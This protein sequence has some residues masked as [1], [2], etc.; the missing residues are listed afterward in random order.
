MNIFF[1]VDDTI[2]SS[3]D[4]SL[5]PLVK[6]VFERITADG[7]HIY[8]WSGVGLRWYEID[9]HGLRSLIK[10]CYVKPLWDH[11]RRLS[12]L[13]VDV[14]PHFVIDDYEEVVDVFGGHTIK[15]YFRR[16]PADQEMVRVYEK[17]CA[18]NV[19]AR[20]SL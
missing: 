9:K 19:D 10:D 3:W 11:R 1:D 6:E 12:L 5:R 7:H 18:Y 13:G 16:D 14:E 2:V 8:I 20:R 17:I 4:G 15:P